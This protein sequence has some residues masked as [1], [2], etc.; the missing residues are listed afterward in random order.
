MHELSWRILNQDFG[1]KN[2]LIAKLRG[3]Y[4]DQICTLLTIMLQKKKLFIIAI[5]RKVFL[6]N[7]YYC[8]LVFIQ[9][10]ICY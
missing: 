6:I 8:T 10:W 7:I 2:F 3:N 9:R 1:N 5:S 4:L